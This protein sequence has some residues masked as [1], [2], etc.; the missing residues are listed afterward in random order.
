M[1]RAMPIHTNYSDAIRSHS[2]VEGYSLWNG[3]KR[4]FQ[5]L[6]NHP[7]TVVAISLL[8]T[9]A[10]SYFFG[11]FSPVQHCTNPLCK[12]TTPEGAKLTEK[13]T[14]VCTRHLSQVGI[15]PNDLADKN[16][17]SARLDGYQDLRCWVNVNKAFPKLG[18][19][20]TGVT[21]P[22]SELTDA[23]KACFIDFENQKELNFRLF[24][25]ISQ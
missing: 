20:I 17:V 18:Y 1:A 7:G 13:L 5:W 15:M 8:S 11:V 2:V 22:F 24:P 25:L 19:G 14:A 4:S 9:L 16:P 3:V 6:K 21:A 12:Y 10:I 23:E